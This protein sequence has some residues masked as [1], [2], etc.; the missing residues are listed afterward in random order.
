M[1]YASY[2]LQ[3]YWSQKHGIHVVGDIWNKSIY[4]EDPLITYSRLYCN[5]NQETLYADLYDYASRMVSYDIDVICDYKTDDAIDYSTTRYLCEYNFY[6]DV[7][8]IYSG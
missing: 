6:Q 7:Y 1:R 4:P 3:Y 5:N 2:W 8:S